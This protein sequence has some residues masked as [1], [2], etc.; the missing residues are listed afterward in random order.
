MA[1]VPFFDIAMSNWR[2]FDQLMDTAVGPAER[3]KPLRL[4]RYT[5]RFKR[6]YVTHKGMRFQLDRIKAR[7][8]ASPSMMQVLNCTFEAG[9]DPEAVLHAKEYA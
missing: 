9:L 2:Y 6:R 4:M 7:G 1:P 3:R 5:I 8:G